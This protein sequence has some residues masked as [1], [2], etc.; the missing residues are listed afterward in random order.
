MLN[1]DAANQAQSSS[2]NIQVRVSYN[3]TRGYYLTLP[4]TINPLPGGF[5]QALL[6]K[7]S[8]SCTT[9]EVKIV[10]CLKTYYQPISLAPQILSL[11]D[12]AREALDQALLTTCT[13]IQDNLIQTYIRPQLNQLFILADSIVS[14]LSPS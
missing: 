4:N 6:N 11:S 5:I 2:G 8:I 1:A 10:S 7:K 9:K 14:C 13:I 12:R 3:T